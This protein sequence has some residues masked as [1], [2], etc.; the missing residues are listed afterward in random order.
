MH[1]YALALVVRYRV[2]APL[3]NTWRHRLR[4]EAVVP[5]A[6]GVVS[7]IMRGAHLDELGAEAGQFFRWRFLTAATWRTAHPF[8]LSAPP[9]RDHL[10]ITVK[11]L[12]DGSALVHSVRAGTLVLAEGPSGALTARRRTRPSVLL[13]AGGVGITPMRALFETLPIG[14]GRLRGCCRTSMVSP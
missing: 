1:A 4:V 9:A 11:A 8:S 6:D 13:I 10:R 14:H 12:G 3:E 7:V 2:V 5:E